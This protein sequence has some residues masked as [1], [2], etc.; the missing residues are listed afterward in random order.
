MKHVALTTEV[1]GE[2]MGMVKWVGT[3]QPLGAERWVLVCECAIAA[4]VATRQHSRRAC[5]RGGERR[6]IYAGDGLQ[7]TTRTS[8]FQLRS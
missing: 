3:D 1:N 2:R 5:I 4:T 7:R 6:Y 8:S